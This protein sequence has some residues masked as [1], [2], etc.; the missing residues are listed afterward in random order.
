MTVLAAENLSIGYGSTVVATGINLSLRAGSIT[1]LLGPNGV[2][3]TTLFKTLLG[4]IAPLAGT[5]RVGDENLSRLSRAAIA[6]QIAYVPQAYLGDFAYT[7]LDLVVMGRTAYI[8]A[9]GSVTKADVDIAM[10][11]LEALGITALAQRDATRVSGGQRQLALVARA[12]AQQANIIV[13]D[14]PT[15]SLDLGNRLLILDRIR[16]LATDGLPSFCPRTS[17]NRRLLWPT[18]WRCSDGNSISKQDHPKRSSRRSS[19]PRFMEWT[20]W[21]NKRRRDGK[22]SVHDSRADQSACPN[23]D[24]GHTRIPILWTTPRC[25]SKAMLLRSRAPPSLP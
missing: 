25:L 9:F 21:L 13:M 1:C 16:K 18:M 3:K 10:E 24:P 15:A 6:R 19:S 4:L 7:V 17:R 5:I 20:S 8:G 12:L 14:E 11:A 2:G 23:G 22:W